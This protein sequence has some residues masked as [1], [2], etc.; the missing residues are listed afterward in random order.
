MLNSGVRERVALKDDVGF[1]LIN[2]FESVPVTSSFT[3]KRI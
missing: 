3:K 1:D 2:V